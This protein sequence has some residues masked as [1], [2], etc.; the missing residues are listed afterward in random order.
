MRPSAC[1]GLLRVVAARDGGICRIKLPGGLLPGEHALAIA[2]A[3]ERYA[4]GTIELTNRANLQIRGVHA[5]DEAA[6][7][8]ALLAAGLGPRHC[9]ADALMA[10]DDLRN[11]MLSPAAGIDASAC[12]D[13]RTLIAPV[14]EVLQ[15][16]AAISPK[17]ALQIDGGE[18]LAMLD[19]PH[20]IWLAAFEAADGVRFAFGL[21]G[22][23]ASSAL[24]SVLPAQV[25][26][27][28]A[29]LLHAFLDLRAADET[30]MRDVLARLDADA[31]LERT[32]YHLAFDLPRDPALAAWR[33]SAADPARRFGIH[34]QRDATRSHVGAQPALGRTTSATLRALAGLAHD[35]G[36]GTLRITPWQGV[37]LPNVATT[38]APDVLAQLAA[39]GLVCA[40]DAPLARLI[41]C[42]GSTGCVKGRADTKADAQRLAG[43]LPPHVEVHLS[44]CE[45][46][47]AA[48]HR[49]PYTLLACAPGRYDLYE[50]DASAGFGRCVARHLTIDE[51]AA[52]LVRL[53]RSTPDV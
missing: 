48:A 16:F 14:I 13:T 26:A 41:A 19:H 37:L 42:S 23:P 53:A 49:A 9:A 39:L 5:G 15:R 22:T 51:T 35:H 32:R 36:D 43:L 30:R 47:C 1:P 12:F 44:G 21:A 11:L 4:D 38:D 40:A 27:L 6:L 31:V 46:S 50:R 52:L 8:A 3:A 2:D 45:R 18:R 17:F 34:A 7:G 24:A 25:P 20:D 29:A 10:A 28:V 33:R